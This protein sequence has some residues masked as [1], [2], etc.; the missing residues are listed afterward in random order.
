MSKDKP[1]SH[2]SQLFP[3]SLKDLKQSPIWRQQQETIAKLHEGLPHPYTPEQ[4]EQLRAM[5]KTP[6]LPDVSLPPELAEVLREERNQQVEPEPAVEPTAEV[7][8]EPTAE[9]TPVQAVEEA[10][11]PTA[12]PTVEPTEVGKKHP[13]GRPPIPPALI[14]AAREEYRPAV[15]K[16]GHLRKPELARKHLNAWLGKSPWAKQFKSLSLSSWKKHVIR[17]TLAE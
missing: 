4:V 12:E 2:R 7:T 17:P 6:P 5:L 8:V 10:V 14:Q 13:G 3:H 9:P 11:E 15:E 16:N 1:P